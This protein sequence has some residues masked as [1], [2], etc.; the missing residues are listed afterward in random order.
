SLADAQ[1][2][3]R[4]RALMPVFHR[5]RDNARP[6]VKAARLSPALTANIRERARQE[7]ATVHAALCA[8]LL[9]ASRDVLAAWGEIPL[10]IFSPLNARSQR[11]GE[12]CGV[13]L[14]A[15]TSV[16]DKQTAGFWDIAREAKAGV[17][18]NSTREHMAA[19]L[20]LL[21]Q[22]VGNG[23]DVARAAAI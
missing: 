10:R 1:E 8:A 18:A 17:A 16:F 7:G 4:P 14:G 22:A 9:L 23:A 15:A 12:S 21:R 3:D 5:P 2:Q 19:R 11:A 6:T 20:S 13:F